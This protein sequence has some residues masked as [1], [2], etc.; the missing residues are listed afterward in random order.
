MNPR[1]QAPRWPSPYL[2][3]PEASRVPLHPGQRAN[4]HTP[5]PPSPEVAMAP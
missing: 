3:Y 4:P 5:G 1:G 2:T